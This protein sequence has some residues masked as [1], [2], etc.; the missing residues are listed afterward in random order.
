MTSDAEKFGANAWVY[1]ASHLR[2]H[3]TGWCTVHNDQKTPL[4]ARAYKEA[5]AECR[6]KGLKIYGD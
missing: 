3:E 5:F 4:E 1:C 2:P 6:A